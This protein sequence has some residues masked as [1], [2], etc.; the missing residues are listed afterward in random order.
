[1]EAR[2]MMKRWWSVWVVSIASVGG[3]VYGWGEGLFFPCGPIDRYLHLSNCAIIGHWDGTVV[4]ALV[5]SGSNGLTAVNRDAVDGSQAPQYFVDVSLTGNL[6]AEDPI[7]STKP[8]DAW[9]KAVAAPDGKSILAAIWNEGVWLIDRDTGSRTTRYEGAYSYGPIG[10]APDGD[11]LIDNASPGSFDRPVEPSA[12]RYERDGT[13]RGEVKGGQAW[14]IY[15]DGISSAAT[16]DGALMFQHER[17]NNDTG[18]VAV[19]VIEPQFATWGGALLVAPIGGWIDQ[20][21][22][23]ISVSPDGRFVAASF[24]ST[25]EWGQIN[26]ALAIWEVESRDLITLVPTWR[27]EWENIVWLTEG[28]LAASRYNIDWHGSDVAI[29]TYE[30]QPTSD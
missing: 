20:I 8:D 18:I 19:R 11:V 5:T 4:E 1:M 17:T 6:G 24:D 15:T 30:R 23:L 10:F 26:S 2:R 27:A 21:L 12:L 7:A 3:L 13:G 16:A 29:I 14:S 22:P 25:D 28:R 9:M